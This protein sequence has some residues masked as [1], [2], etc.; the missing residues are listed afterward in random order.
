M[1]RYVQAIELRGKSQEEQQEQKAKNDIC[2][3]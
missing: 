3:S 2:T 1:K